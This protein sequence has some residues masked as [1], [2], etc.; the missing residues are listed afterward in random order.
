MLWFISPAR[1]DVGVLCTLA[2]RSQQSHGLPWFICGMAGPPLGRGGENGTQ[3]LSCSCPNMR[4]CSHFPES[5]WTEEGTS[6]LSSF[7]GDHLVVGTLG[8]PPSF[9]L[10]WVS[11]T[12]EAWSAN[13]SPSLCSLCTFDC[14]WT[15]CPPLPPCKP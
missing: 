11:G 13:S 8:T 3:S 15:C 12:V 14:G 6:W 7:P 4:V 5:L 10:V 1:G 9:S 2:S